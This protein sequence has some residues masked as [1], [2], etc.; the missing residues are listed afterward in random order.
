MS[1]SFK[2]RT[3]LSTKNIMLH[4]MVVFV[5]FIGQVEVSITRA[6]KSMISVWFHKDKVEQKSSTLIHWTLAFFNF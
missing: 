1:S 6:D 4:T 5:G 3:G 2:L